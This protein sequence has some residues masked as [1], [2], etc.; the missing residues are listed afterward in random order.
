MLAM[1]LLVA[2]AALLDAS[3]RGMNERPL[4]QC[5][6]EDLLNDGQFESQGG[7]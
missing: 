6:S 5:L 4:S 1:Q 7:R 3:N 2:V